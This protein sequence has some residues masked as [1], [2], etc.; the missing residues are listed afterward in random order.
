MAR[1]PKKDPNAPDAEAV[2]DAHPR[3]RVIEKSFIGHS[4]HE[5]GAE[6]T[7]H[8]DTVSDNLSPLNAAAQAVVDAQKDPH[9]D[10]SDGKKPKAPRKPPEAVEADPADADSGE[11]EEL[12]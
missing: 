3:Y 5:E 10:K 8:G 12:A 7:Y 1:S 2:N 6:L 4:L 11:D 9:L